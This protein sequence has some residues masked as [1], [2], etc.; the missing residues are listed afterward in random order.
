M[1]KLSLLFIILLAQLCVHAQNAPSFKT[2]KMCLSLMLESNN[3]KAKLYDFIN[4]ETFIWYD[5][6]GNGNHLKNNTTFPY[7]KTFMPQLHNN[8]HYK[9]D[10]ADQ[11]HFLK[12][13]GNEYL[14]L[15]NAKNIDFTS[16]T[17]FIVSHAESQADINLNTYISLAKFSEGDLTDHEEF[18]VSGQTMHHH[19]KGGVYKYIGNERILKEDNQSGLKITTAVFGENSDD[20]KLYCNNNAQ[21]QSGLQNSNYSGE[22]V[23]AYLPVPRSIYLGRRKHYYENLIGELNEIIVYEGKLSAPQI[24][25]VNKYLAHKYDIMIFK[26]NKEERLYLNNNTKFINK[27][28]PLPVN[29]APT[30]TAPPEIFIREY[31]TQPVQISLPSINLNIENERLLPE[32]INYLPKDKYEFYFKAIEYMHP[33]TMFNINLVNTAT[34]KTEFVDAVD[35]TVGSKFSID[36]NLIIPNT[37]YHLIITNSGNNN[38]IQKVLI[39]TP[40]KGGELIIKEIQGLKKTEIKPQGW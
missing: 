32:G 23:A 17:I 3:A 19:K 6:S 33:T 12:F 39:H 20:M 1:K 18:L 13:T 9:L 37:K 26:Q 27:T 14:Y 40:S 34:N 30:T 5:Q 10:G 16:C 2:N 36:K 11:R 22:E 4:Y 8:V 29:N 15:E 21:K 7:A 35:G 25:Q 31:P 24:E 38:L 28:K